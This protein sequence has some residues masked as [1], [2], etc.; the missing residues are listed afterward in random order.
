VERYGRE[1]ADLVIDMMY[2]SYQR[3]CLVAHTQDDLEAY[4]PRA[5]EVAEFCARR[6]GMVYEE[7][8]GSDALIVGL[9][10]APHRLEELG[11]EFVVVPPQGVVEQEM[12][13][14][15]R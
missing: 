11:E 2:E 12:F 1:R 8:L 7:R 9:L 3:L 4:R 15:D 5:R 6:W 10:S 13:L 14:P